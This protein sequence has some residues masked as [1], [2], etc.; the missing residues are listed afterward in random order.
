MLYRIL[1]RI[2]RE[3]ESV[4]DLPLVESRWMVNALTHFPMRLFPATERV[5]TAFARLF[6]IYDTE[7]RRTVSRRL[8]MKA[9]VLE[10][11][12]SLIEAPLAVAVKKGKCNPK[13]NAVVERM[14]NTPVADYSI[15][16]LAREVGLS[17]VAFFETF[18]RATGLPPHAFLL[19]VRIKAAA[20][21]L[22]DLSVSVADI[23]KRYRF[24]SSQHFATAFR[25]IM[26]VSPRR[27]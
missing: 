18:K 26:G 9:A 11:L 3:G 19:D 6:A 14:R 15:E 22:E 8:K 25:R 27:R 24:S 2:P 1:F 12:L 16:A 13:V 17:T 4:L 21:D 10:L 20:R 7:R 5:K 23:A